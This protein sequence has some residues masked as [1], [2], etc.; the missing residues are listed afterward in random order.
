M[1][2]SYELTKEVPE[3]PAFTD[4]AGRRCFER[5]LADLYSA[6]PLMDGCIEYFCKQIDSF[7]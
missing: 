2:G 7:V 4:N 6:C 1:A 5:G 3:T